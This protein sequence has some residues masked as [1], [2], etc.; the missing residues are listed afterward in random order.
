MKTGKSKRIV[1]VD[2]PKPLDK[3]PRAKSE[4]QEEEE[5]KEKLWINTEEETFKWNVVADEIREVLYKSGDITGQIV[6]KPDPEQ[7]RRYRSNAPIQTGELKSSNIKEGSIVAVDWDKEGWRRKKA[8]VEIYNDDESFQ[9]ETKAEIYKPQRGGRQSGRTT[10][11]VLQSLLYALENK[12]SQVW[13]FAHDGDFCFY[14]QEMFNDMAVASK[15]LQ[16]SMSKPRHSWVAGGSR[17]YFVSIQSNPS[18]VRGR[19]VHETFWDHLLFESPDYAKQM[20]IWQPV[21]LA[22]IRERDDK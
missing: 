9:K 17:V 16:G 15:T 4:E 11:M 13:V 5:K 6:I 10:R 19:Y 22:S 1:E 8:K 2:P 21:V 12:D 7:G 14:L 18:T 3:Q 20:A